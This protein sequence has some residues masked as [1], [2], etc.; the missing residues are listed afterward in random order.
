MG[1]LFTDIGFIRWPMTFSLLAVIAL[2][3]WSGWRLLAG[4]AADMRQKA[5]IDAI[6]FWGGFALVSGLL[7][8]LV[9]VIVAAQRI[10]AAGSIETVLLWGGIKVALLISALGVMILCF[11]A[12]SWFVLQLRWRLLAAG[13]AS[14]A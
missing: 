4:G 8:T 6:L 2:T 13:G 1:A 3:A 12:I 11:A 5:W 7:G 9:R 14:G 10:E